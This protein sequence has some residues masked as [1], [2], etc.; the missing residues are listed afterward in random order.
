MQEKENKILA[1]IK[2]R[3]RIYLKAKGIKLKDF[4]EETGITMSNY[5]ARHSEFGGEAIAQILS[6]Y[7]DISPFWLIL[8][9]GDML[10][11]P[12]I[13]IGNIRGDN[14]VYR[15]NVLSAGASHANDI[16]KLQGEHIQ[17]LEEQI[18]Y[19]MK[20]IEKRDEQIDILVSALANSN[21]KQK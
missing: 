18:T 15:D 21:N 11:A 9:R 2:G 1:P 14:N 4:L 19:L 6:S 17:R 7:V 5:K 13:E 10:Q 8:G 20:I 16:V 12:L 3:V